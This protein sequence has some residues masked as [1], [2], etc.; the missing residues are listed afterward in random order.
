MDNI[1]RKLRVSDGFLHDEYDMSNIKQMWHKVV[2]D[3]TVDIQNAGS[4]DDCVFDSWVRSV[5]Y[6]VPVTHFSEDRFLNKQK[7]INH[8]SDYKGYLD[9]IKPFLIEF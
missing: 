4:V 2:K 9:F 1:V 8:L 5:K 3:K 6:N 7:Y